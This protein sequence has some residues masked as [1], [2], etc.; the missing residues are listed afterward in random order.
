MRVLGTGVSTLFPGQCPVRCTM[1][2]KLQC[3][4]CFRAADGPDPVP[5]SSGTLRV[6][7]A[8]SS[9]PIIS[10]SCYADNKSWISSCMVAG[11]DLVIL[12]V[13]IVPYFHPSSKLYC[14][15]STWG[16]LLLVF[17]PSVLPDFL[18]PLYCPL[19]NEMPPN[20]KWYVCVFLVSHCVLSSSYRTLIRP[21]FRVTY[22]QVT[23]LEW[24]CCPGFVGEE[25]REGE[26]FMCVFSSLPWCHFLKH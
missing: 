16:P 8:N 21:S 15:G 1:G 10:F 17:R 26:F 19:S 12:G 9:F 24:R 3:R 11:V 14:F 6:P 7:P 23:A 13:S 2:Q 25:C 5:K 4:E 20:T 22:K 18:S